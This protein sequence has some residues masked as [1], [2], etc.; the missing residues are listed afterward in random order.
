[1][2]AGKHPHERA[3]VKVRS[4]YDPE[5]QLLRDRVTLESD[6]ARSLAAQYL[7]MPRRRPPEAMLTDENLDRAALAATACRNVYEAL[8]QAREVTHSS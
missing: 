7:G 2:P 1:M 3:A 4:G 6:Y 5:V 8:R